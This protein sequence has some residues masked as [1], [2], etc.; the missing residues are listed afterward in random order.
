MKCE[1]AR[2][3]LLQKC[4]ENSNLQQSAGYE[5]AFSDL[6]THKATSI[7][8]YLIFIKKSILQNHTRLHVVWCLQQGNPVNLF[9][10]FLYA[11]IIQQGLVCFQLIC[12]FMTCSLDKLSYLSI[13]V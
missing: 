5:S 13:D 12:F 8:M 3:Q 7:D 10:P 1:K 4:T 9:P 2:G 6:A 11:N